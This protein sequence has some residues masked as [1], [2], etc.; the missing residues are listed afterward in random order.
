[1][2]AIEA[3]Q[4]SVWVMNLRK[5]FLSE[6]KKHVVHDIDFRRSPTGLEGAIAKRAKC[7]ESGKIMK[8]VDGPHGAKEDVEDDD[9]KSPHEVAAMHGML[10][11]TLCRPQ[12]VDDKAAVAITS[13]SISSEDDPKY[14]KFNEWN[15]NFKAQ[16][17]KWYDGAEDDRANIGNDF[18]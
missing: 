9:V 8:H 3:F 17:K 1:M 18:C 13:P 5:Q 16:Y 14:N 10:H 15:V 11:V 2:L 7:V 6:I 4:R 12:M